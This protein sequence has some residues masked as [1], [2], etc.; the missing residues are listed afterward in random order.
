MSWFLRNEIMTKIM[1]IS[2]TS[3]LIGV[4]LNMFL[5]PADVFSSGLNG[6][7]QLVSGGFAKYFNLTIDTGLL[8]FLL[9]VPVFLISW[10]R[11]GPSATIFS[12]F[13]VLGTSLITMIIP[14]Y[15]VTDNVLVNAIVG[16]VLVGIGAGLCLKFG[17][18]TGGVDVIA[19]VIAK[20]SGKTVGSLMFGINMLIVVTAGVMYS[21]ESA[22][23]SI[24]SIYCQ[25][26]VID[27]IHTGSQKVTAF[28]VTSETEKVVVAIKKNITRGMTLIDSRGGYKNQENTTIMMVISRYELFE[29]EKTVYQVDGQAFINILPTYNVFGMYW[30]EEQQ[31]AQQKYLS[32]QNLLK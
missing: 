32:D 9:N 3:L 1:I 28:I 6:V 17:F 8:I 27:S 5:I 12:F 25:T 4:A 18:T 2:V 24:I 20:T 30:S 21:W 26:Q 16:G 7:S 22:I 29:L 14:E 11:L 19:A 15:V 31:R 13:T 23:Y 10:L